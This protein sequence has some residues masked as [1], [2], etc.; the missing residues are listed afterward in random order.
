MKLLLEFGYNKFIVDVPEDN[1]EAVAQL[2]SMQLGCMSVE[3]GYTRTKGQVYYESEESKVTISRLPK[4][5]KVISKEDYDKTRETEKRE[6][7]DRER[8]E[9]LAKT[10]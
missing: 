1:K 7:E 8:A 3:C 9:E 4:K 6:D 2:I 10:S 5:T